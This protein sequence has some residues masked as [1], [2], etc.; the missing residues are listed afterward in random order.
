V[1]AQTQAVIRNFMAQR[2]DLI[3]SD[4][5]K[6]TEN[7]NGGGPG[8]DGTP[9]NLTA[10]GVPGAMDMAFSMSL[11]Q[12]ARAREAQRDAKRPKIPSAMGV[13]PLASAPTD[14]AP[15]VFDIWLKGTYANYRDSAGG[16]DE[17]GTFGLL[18]VGAEYAVAT[19][20]RLGLLAQFDWTEEEDERTNISAEGQGWMVGPYLAARPADRVYVQARAAWGKSDNEVSPFGTYRDSF[21]TSRWLASAKIEGRY[22]LGPWRVSPIAGVIYYEDKQNGYTDS[23]G[24]LIGGQTAALGR[25]TFGPEISYSHTW[26]NGRYLQLTSQVT[27]I[28]DFDV[29]DRVVSAQLVG[30][31]EVRAKLSGGVTLHGT[32]GFRVNATGFVDGLGADD[33][34]SYGGN[35]K[36]NLSLN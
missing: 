20:L 4:D 30:T 29:E 35:I 24:N 8:A 32:S 19:G 25:A 15:P 10:N 34:E 13:G 27:G 23:L 26:E 28:W 5:P 17:D 22:G 3:T 7:L 6:L 21:E 1:V 16:V 11:S 12:V 9:F 31:E 18:Y 33:F 2:A 36:L 14:N